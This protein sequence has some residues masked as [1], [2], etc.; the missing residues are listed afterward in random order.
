MAGTYLD[1]IEGTQGSLPDS[2]TYTTSISEL[3]DIV[4]I[5]FNSHVSA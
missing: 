5:Q 3:S 4:I 2:C 1:W